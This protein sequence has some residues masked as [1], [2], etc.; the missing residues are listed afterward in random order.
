MLEQAKG[1]VGGVGG[2]DVVIKAD[3]F[4]AFG[5]DGVELEGVGGREGQR[6]GGEDVK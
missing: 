4:G 3:E 2:L 5:S 6:E 1:V